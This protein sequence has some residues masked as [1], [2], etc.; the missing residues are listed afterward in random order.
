MDMLVAACCSI[1]VVVLSLLSKL[2]FSLVYYS[3]EMA[4]EANNLSGKQKRRGTALDSLR[5]TSVLT[6]DDIQRET[7]P[8]V[9][10]ASTTN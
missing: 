9:K 2:F 1:Q 8:C 10:L 7:N 5:E 4:L 3:I 6:L